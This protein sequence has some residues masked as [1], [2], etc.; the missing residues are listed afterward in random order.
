[1]AEYVNPS[2]SSNPLAVGVSEFLACDSCARYWLSQAW[3]NMAKVRPVGQERKRDVV[4]L[5]KFT[6][7]QDY[8]NHPLFELCITDGHSVFRTE[9]RAWGNA[10]RNLREFIR[11]CGDPKAVQLAMVNVYRTGY[12]HVGTANVRL[13]PIV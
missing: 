12:G 9:V 6:F 10:V 8:V 5:T 11:D 2:N 7:H 3:V 13:T 4:P 1:M